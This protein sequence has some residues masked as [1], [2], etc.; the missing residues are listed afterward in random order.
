[1][2]RHP[3]SNNFPVDAGSSA[4]NPTKVQSFDNAPKQRP[5]FSG[6]IAGNM[7]VNIRNP[8]DFRVRV[9]LRSGGRGMDFIVQAHASGGVE[10]PNG[11][12]DVYFQC[13]NDP[14]A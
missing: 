5:R 9:G 12:Y 1:M 2:V 10:V 7:T 14:E 3:G 13:S 4:I 6:V 11:R 8:N